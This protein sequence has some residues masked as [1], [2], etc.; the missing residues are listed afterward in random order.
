MKGLVGRLDRVFVQ[1]VVL[2]YDTLGADR[3]DR[4]CC[5]IDDSLV[6]VYVVYR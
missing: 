6:A 4:I 2:L 5:S 3:C 1:G